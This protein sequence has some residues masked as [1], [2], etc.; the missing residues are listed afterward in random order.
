MPGL[1]LRTNASAAW[2]RSQTSSRSEPYFRPFSFACSEGLP[3]TGPTK[4]SAS[5]GIDLIG[6]R[7]RHLLEERLR[8]PRP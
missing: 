5:G 3:E 2:K 7:L 1:S 4:F 6:E 8:R